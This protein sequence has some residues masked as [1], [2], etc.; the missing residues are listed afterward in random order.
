MI[1]S[2]RAH[3]DGTVKESS[4]LIA[5][6][7]V[8]GTEVY[9]RAGESIGSIYDLMLDKRSGHVAYAIMSFGGFL[10]IGNSYHPLPW[11]MLEY[12]TGM[13]GYVADLERSQLAKAPS[14]EAS[15]TP[16]WGDEAFE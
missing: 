11:S 8:Q 10:G 12:D 2:R 13:G 4:S 15:A 9:D 6:D 14:Y 3:M 1:S 5:A 7:K 16:A